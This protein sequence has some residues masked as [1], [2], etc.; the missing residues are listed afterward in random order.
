MEKEEDE[1][2][3]LENELK[4]LEHLKSN[5]YYL[6]TTIND[7]ELPVSLDEFKEKIKNIFHLEKRKNDEIFIFYT[8]LK[9]EEDD[10]DEENNNNNKE[11]LLEVKNKE[12]FILLLQRIKLNEVK[13]ETIYIETD[14]VPSEISRKCPET[15]E[16]EIECLVERE[17]KAASERIKKYL[18]GNKKCFSKNKIQNSKECSNC[19]RTIIGDIYRSVTNIEESIYCERCSFVKNEPTFII[20]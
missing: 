4:E 18:S 3:K 10:D 6:N 2:I 14:K 12:N 5:I 11:E 15:F 16:E 13:D 7:F 19:G 1:K 8:H 9:E 17:L 20:H